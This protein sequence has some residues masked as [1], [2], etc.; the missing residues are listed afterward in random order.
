MNSRIS[1]KKLEKICKQYDN[2]YKS[3]TY[4]PK[5]GMDVYQYVLTKINEDENNGIV[6]G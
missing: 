6:R 3:L 1:L 5:Y 2:L 4:S